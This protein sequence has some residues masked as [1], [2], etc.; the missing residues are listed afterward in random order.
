MEIELLI[1]TVLG[2]LTSAVLVFQILLFLLSKY[3]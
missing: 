3:D 2:G 1:K